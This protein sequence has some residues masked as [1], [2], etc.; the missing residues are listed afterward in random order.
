M[1]TSTPTTPSKPPLTP[2]SQESVVNYLNSALALYVTSFNIRNQL[3]QRD[4]AYLRTQDLTQ[5]NERARLANQ[6]GDASKKQNITV[7]VVMPQVEAAVAFHVEVFLT[8]YPLFGVVAPPDQMEAQTQFESVIIDQSTQAAWVP[9]L[10][11]TIRDGLKYDLGAVEVTWETKKM[12]NIAAPKSDNITNGTPQETYYQ[13]NFL[14]HL[15]AY[16]LIFDTRVN[17]AVNHLKG[18]YAGYTELLSRIALKKLMEDLSPMYTMNF[19]QAL[20]S[21]TTST[22]VSTDATAGFYIPELN[23]DALLP[24][25]ARQSHDWSSW[26]NNS[27]GE[28]AIQYKDSYEVTVLY[29]RILPSDFGIDVPQR[30]HVQIYKFII[31]NRQVVIY[32]EKLTNAHNMLPIIICKPNDDGLELQGKSFAEN[33]IPIQQLSSSLVNSAIESQRRKVY[34]RIFYDPTR[35]APKDINNTSAVARIPVK[36]TMYS[37]NIQEAMYSVPYRDDGIGEILQ[38]SQ[39]VVEMGNV[40]NGSNRVAQGQFQKGNKTRREFDT[41]MSNS[42]ARQRTQALVLEYNFFGPIKQIIKSNILQYQP[43]SKLMAPS[44][45]AMVDVDPAK[46]RAAFLKFNLSD[47][48][49]PTEKIAS[50]GLLENLIQLGF[51]VPE[52]RLEYDIPGMIAYYYSLMGARWLGDFKRNDT[53]KAEYLQQ[54]QSATMASNPNQGKAPPAKTGGEAQ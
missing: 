6:R 3:V 47:G 4:T 1:A 54:M 51:T 30:N 40:I 21:G 50:T 10:I 41:V 34:D 53:Q 25:N 49:L 12:F 29:A 24:A 28:P 33:V 44:G 19:K 43:P 32:A 38:L 35:I 11:K 15:N 8:G 17:P 23:P 2:S 5:E 13:G 16:N 31:V 20:E 14:K 27:K 36:S 37:K 18:E 26:W 48:L 9:E 52:V 22:Y 7:P 45:G 42:N 39:Q 46:L